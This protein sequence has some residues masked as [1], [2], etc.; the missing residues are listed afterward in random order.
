[1]AT[2]LLS[3]VRNVARLS[4][5][6]RLG[7]LDTPPEAAFDRLAR[8]ACRVLHTPVAL[9]SLVDRDRQEKRGPLRHQM[10]AL[11]GQFPF[12]SEIRFAPR[13]GSRRDD[14]DKERARLD[15]AADFLV[16]RI[17]AFEPVLIEP[18][19]DVEGR[20]RIRDP[21]RCREVF[22]RVTQK[23]GSAGR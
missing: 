15:L 13:L 19:L 14:G 5:L 17:A 9:V 2:E 12:Q 10:R 1:M 11:V 22:A 23:N 16:P 7:L 20:Q 3:I 8:V 18:H 4:A 21:P 6:Q